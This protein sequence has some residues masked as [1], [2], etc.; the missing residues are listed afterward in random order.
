MN[1]KS[2]LK[3]KIL[4]VDDSEMNRLILS[5]MLEEDF[6]FLRRRTGRRAWRSCSR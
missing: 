4:I 1:D 3:E 6:G 2:K 5:D